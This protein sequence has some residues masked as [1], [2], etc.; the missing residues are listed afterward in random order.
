METNLLVVD[1]EVLFAENLCVRLAAEGYGAEHVTTAE[2][3]LS[4]LADG[5]SYDLVVMDMDLGPGNMSGV[6]A[7]RVI[8]RDYDVPVL[9]YTGHSDE[10]TVA[11]ARE[12]DSYGC[13]FKSNGD[14]QAL[15]ASISAAVRRSQA[16]HRI[17]DRNSSLLSLVDGMDFF[18]CVVDR[19]S[20]T[21]MFVNDS[22]RKQFGD[23]TGLHY[24]DALG[25]E[26]PP[27]ARD[28]ATTPPGSRGLSR[29]GWQHESVLRHPESGRWYA[30]T[31]RPV[32][33]ENSRDA[34][35]VVAI[36]VSKQVEERTALA[37][38]LEYA[39]LRLDEV[40]HR[41]KNNLVLVTSLIRFA[42][43]HLPE[44]YDLAAL[45]HQIR[46]VRMLHERLER[47]AEHMP[48]ELPGYLHDIVTTVFQESG[49]YSVQ[50]GLDVPQVRLS[51]KS[52]T[53]LGLI[54]TELAL[55][56][57]KH[58]FDGEGPHQFRIEGRTEADGWLVLEIAN[59]GNAFPDGVDLATPGTTGL[60]LVVAL[61]QQLG[62]R[63]ELDRDGETRFRIR[64]PESHLVGG[65]DVD[66]T[67]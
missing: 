50:I 60:R 43:Q 49:P 32:A 18:V 42:E 5:G 17:R 23:V 37:E 53:P 26:D 16:E 4:R 15:L 64:L 27:Q 46:A 57:A 7:T 6:E 12:V 28:D 52:A 25:I 65:T 51:S 39:R 24:K 35:L 29:A 33:W 59:D 22:V 67:G 3:C 36:D 2:S 63:L 40:N 54:V 41:I 45:F 31:V 48:V 9:F 61:T 66:T 11:P 47:Y 13:V 1:D 10:P 38:E 55:N 8:R 44:G 56:A 20:G 34:F 21:L 19:P 14:F 62:G 58:A 30:L